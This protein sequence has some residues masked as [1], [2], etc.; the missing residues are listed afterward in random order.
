LAT[1]L[2]GSTRVFKI[3]FNKGIIEVKNA[4]LWK[5]YG[6]QADKSL[7]SFILDVDCWRLLAICPSIN[8]YCLM[9]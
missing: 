2:V 1:K 6:D 9:S 8:Y 4:S 3:V 5:V 7:N